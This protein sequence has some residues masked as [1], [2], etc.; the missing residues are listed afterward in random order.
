[1][2]KEKKNKISDIILI[3]IF[4]GILLFFFLSFIFIKPKM[5]SDTEKRKLAEFPKVSL[6]TILSGEFMVGFE[7]YINDHIVFKDEMVSL[8]NYLKLVTGQKELNGVVIGKDDY[9]FNKFE[10]NEENE[11]NIDK[12]IEFLNLFKYK[13]NTVFMLVPTSEGVIENKFPR[14]YTPFNQKCLIDNIYNRV[15]L[16]CVDVYSLLKENRLYIE[17]IYYK[18]DPHWTMQG[19][20]YGYLALCEKLGIEPLDYSEL[21]YSVLKNGYKGSTYSKINM[22]NSEDILYKLELVKNLPVQI[23]INEEENI[24]NDLYFT[25]YLDSIDNYSVYLGG[26]N[27]I[28][29]VKSNV[30]NGKKLLIIKDSFSHTLVPYLINHYSEIV[31]IDFRYYALS[32]NKLIR[33]EKFDDI[34]IIYNIENFK[35][36]KRLIFLTR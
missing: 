34:A 13:D 2:K 35:N 30:D 4:C 17:N 36:D 10:C 15:D 5:Y 26:N 11:R 23:Q 32:V 27:G 1:M 22:L 6:S 33:E 3:L 19:S 31:L 9:L 24:F 28:V 12:S 16:N 18:T 8:G 29:R 20:Y 25:K 7:E 14:W 21:S